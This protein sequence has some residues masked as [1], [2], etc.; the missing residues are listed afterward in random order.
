MYGRA[1]ADLKL[2]DNTDPA[3]LLPYEDE[4]RVYRAMRGKRTGG[5][6]V[7]LL[8]F[9]PNSGTHNR[10]L[11]M[12]DFRMMDPAKDGSEIMME[13]SGMTAVITGRNLLPVAAGIGAGWVAALEAF[14]PA[15]RDMP[16]DNAP[17]IE[18]I[19][20]F[21]PGNHKSEVSEPV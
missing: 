8:L 16:A 10:Y 11:P 12:A 6:K 20:F 19:R 18:T 2:I 3:E 9:V 4:G 5:P 21:M 13:F 1:M 17:L 14:D 15:L 7:I